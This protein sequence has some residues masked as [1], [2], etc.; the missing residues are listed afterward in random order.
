MP[1]VSDILKNLGLS[2]LSPMQEAMRNAAATGRED[3]VLLSQTGSGKTLAYLLSLIGSLPPSNGALHAIVISPS[4]ELAMQ[5]EE[6]L[7][8][9]KTGP[10]SQC[11]IGGHSTTIERKQMAAISPDVLFVTPG[12]LNYYLSEQLLDASHVSLLIIDE[13]DKCL[14]FGFAEEMRDLRKKLPKSLRTWLISAT[15]DPTKFGEFVK[16]GETQILDFTTNSETDERLSVFKVYSHQKDKLETLGKLLTY[17]K[18]KSAIVFV[19]HRESV[20]RVYSYLL[21]EK[22]RAERYHGGMEQKDRERAIYKFRGGS[23]NVLVAT[24]LAARGLDI[25]E[26]KSV[27][28]YHLPS[29]ATMQEHRDGRS[30]RWENAGNSYLIIGPEETE[31]ACIPSDARTL[32]G[33]DGISVQPTR[34]QWASL[35][36]GRGKKEKLSKGDIVGFLCKVGRLKGEDIGRIEVGEHQAY[37]TIVSKKLKSTLQA[38]GNEK[39]KGMKTLIEEMK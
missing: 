6:L 15:N 32:E 16:E 1:E 5:S 29:D 30:T 12:R 18:G 11:L 19:A 34:P 9:M 27:I 31:S 10:A 38:V 33:I 2:A 39:I 4:R 36:I 24:D 37:V 23:A 20:E 17:L 22:F 14:D 7:R 13:F 8:R 3:L 21:D 26:V 28:H 25:S 35:Y